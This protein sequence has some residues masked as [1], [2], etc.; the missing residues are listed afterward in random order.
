M[1]AGKRFSVIG[2]PQGEIREVLEG[3]RRLVQFDEPIERF[4]KTAGHVPLPPYIHETLQD[5]E[6]YQTVYASHAGICSSANRRA[7][8]YP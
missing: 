3:S 8:F 2:G 7:A 1:E 4:F 5:G 6:R